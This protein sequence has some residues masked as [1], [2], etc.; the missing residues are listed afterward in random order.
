MDRFDHNRL[1]A[2]RHEM[3]NLLTEA[4]NIIRMEGHSDYEYAKSWIS[5]MDRV[6]GRNTSESSMFKTIE[7]FDVA[8]LDSDEDELD[9]TEDCS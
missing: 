7:S 1:Q 2:I 9:W 3:R 6:L 4:E 5:V 8:E